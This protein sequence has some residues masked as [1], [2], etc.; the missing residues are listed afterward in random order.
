M[1]FLRKLTGVNTIN[2]EG[3]KPSARQ[4]NLSKSVSPLKN[5]ESSQQ[6]GNKITISRKGTIAGHNAKDRPATDPLAG[7]SDGIGG[8]I[9]ELILD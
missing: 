2:N 4:T 9:K 3:A 7:S 6:N 1:D 8:T 5:R